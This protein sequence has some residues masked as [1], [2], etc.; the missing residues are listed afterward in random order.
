[1][2]IIVY[3]A[4][5]A[6]AKACAAAACLFDPGLEVSFLPI[7]GAARS[8]KTRVEDTVFYLDAQAADLRRLVSL[9]ERIGGA[10]APWGV[11]DRG[12]LV[13]DPA[14]LF[15]AGAADYLGKAATKGLVDSG[16]LA[17]VAAYARR[18]A[19]AG[20]P[21][22]CPEEAAAEEP[23]AFPGW[24]RLKSGERYPFRFLYAAVGDQQNLAKRLGDRR[25]DGLRGN[26]AAY[27]AA[28]AEEKGGKLWIRDSVSNLFIFPAGR[29]L[30][31]PVGDLLRFLL[32]RPL[33]GYEVFRMEIPVRYRF[34]L[35]EGDAPWR[36]AGSTGTVVSE[37]VNFIY[38]LGAKASIDGALSVSETSFADIPAHFADLFSDGSPFE[39]RR[40]RYSR[41]FT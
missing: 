12:A 27:L 1:M 21:A 29:S 10:A 13:A 36:P 7:S 31:N 15:H 38:H 23:A 4:D 41:R 9:G 22:D 18:S 39:G 11:L 8:F 6:N 30:F 25:M 37:H 20:E 24:E 40:V 3:C 16:R 34:A 32:N 35:H 28:W 5:P 26:F 2:R 19:G 14:A 17:R 33:I